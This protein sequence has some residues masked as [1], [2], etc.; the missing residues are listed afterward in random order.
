MFYWVLNTTGYDHQFGHHVNLKNI[1]LEINL[2]VY[3]TWNIVRQRA[4]DLDV[5][6]S[7]L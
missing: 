2:V 4:T 6:L 1:I 5:I 3:H 7:D